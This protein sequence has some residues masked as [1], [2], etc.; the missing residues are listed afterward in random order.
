MMLGGEP[1]VTDQATTNLLYSGEQF[2]S[3]LQQQYLRARYYDQGSGRF[4]RVDPFRGS[5]RDP[6]SLHKYA[7]AHSDPV[8]GVDPSGALTVIEQ[9]AVIAVITVVVA[10]TAHEY[11]KT[12][13]LAH[14]INVGLG[15]GAIVA[16]VLASG[17][18]FVVEI[19][20][21]V[22]LLVLFS[23]RVMELW[24]E[25][26]YAE[27]RF[28]R[29]TALMVLYSYAM[30]FVAAMARPFVGLIQWYRAK[31]YRPP[32]QP[33]PYS[34]VVRYNCAASRA[35]TAM[36]NKE[37][38]ASSDGLVYNE[39][40]AHPV[41]GGVVQ[42]T[43]AAVRNRTAAAGVEKAIYYKVKPS[44]L[45]FDDMGD[46]ILPGPVDLTGRNPKVYD[47]PNQLPGGP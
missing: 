1:G 31:F 39:A 30:V 16:L 36:A 34:V 19:S 40:G 4:N 37:I 10:T 25:Y 38:P 21:G 28:D 26:R 29:F 42:E 18:A 15:A 3:D 45:K 32:P 35:R 8:M 6:Q 24:D 11:G 13:D 46:V 43:Q 7:Y 17:P 41:R 12:K 22:A 44:E 2:D 47:I 20:V 14:S 23:E 27:S 33:E 9:L 5:N